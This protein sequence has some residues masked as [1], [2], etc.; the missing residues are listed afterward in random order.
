MLAIEEARHSGNDYDL[1]H[2][3]YSAA[4]NLNYLS[5][6]DEAL[7]MAD[8]SVDRLFSGNEA[9]TAQLMLVRSISL[10][11]LGRVSEAEGCLTECLHL[12][13]ER[14][15]DPYAAADALFLLGACA[16]VRGRHE[17]A[18]LSVTGPDGVG[19]H[20]RRWG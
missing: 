7:A 12:T 15:Q 14:F 9:M 2:L 5:R 10:T 4:D 8:E 20:W 13:R 19:G 17:V 1:A 6:F 18:V 3:L 11:M 16:A